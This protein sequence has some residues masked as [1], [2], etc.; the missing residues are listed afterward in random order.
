MSIENKVPEFKSKDG[1]GTTFRDVPIDVFRHLSIDLGTIPDKE[2]GKIKEIYDWAKDKCPDQ[3][4]DNVLLKISNLENTLGSPALD[5][6]RWDKSW[7]FI[8]IQR[9]INNLSRAK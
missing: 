9:Q 8:K 6:H 3:P 2:I 4:M 5:E 1:G 7:R